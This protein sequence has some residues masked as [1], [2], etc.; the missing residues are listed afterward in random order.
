MSVARLFRKS[1]KL[2]EEAS[3]FT[4]L[5]GCGAL[6]SC[7]NGFASVGSGARVIL[8]LV[9]GSTADGAFSFSFPS[10]G[11]PVVGSDCSAFGDESEEV[12]EVAV[13]P[14]F[15]TLRRRICSIVSLSGASGGAGCWLG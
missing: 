11:E 2:P 9:G 15:A 14:S 12:A 10:T 3:G 4:S 6:A 8:I 13:A 7:A 1:L 5:L